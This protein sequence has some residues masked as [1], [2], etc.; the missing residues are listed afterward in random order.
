LLEFE[1]EI[2]LPLMR[3]LGGDMVEIPVLRM[4]SHDWA[5]FLQSASGGAEKK[6]DAAVL[7]PRLRAAER[8]FIRSESCG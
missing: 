4:V 2:Q 6:L 1:E 3:I 7:R 5:C 8:G